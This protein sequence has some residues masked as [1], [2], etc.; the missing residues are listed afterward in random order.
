MEF[1][2]TKMLRLARASSFQ[3]MNDV[4]DQAQERENLPGSKGFSRV[5]QPG[6]FGCE[7]T[8]LGI[9]SMKVRQQ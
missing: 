5:Q 9:K 2:P 1:C 3:T 7:K 8:P 4:Q 6:G